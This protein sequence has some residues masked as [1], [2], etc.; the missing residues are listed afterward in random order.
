LGNF[1]ASQSSYYVVPAGWVFSSKIQLKLGDSLG[2]LAVD[3]ELVYITFL[4]SKG[5]FELVT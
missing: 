1:Y 4:E 5:I 3:N 2:R